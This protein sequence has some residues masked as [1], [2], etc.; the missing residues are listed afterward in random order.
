MNSEP[1]VRLCVFLSS[2]SEDS[3]IVSQKRFACRAESLVRQ[4]ILTMSVSL[5]SVGGVSKKVKVERPRP[6]KIGGGTQPE[7]G[8]EDL[9]V[10]VDNV[11]KI[12]SVSGVP[13]NN[14]DLLH[15]LQILSANLK[16]SG[17]A[18]E[19]THKVRGKVLLSSFSIIDPQD[20]MDKLNHALMSACRLEQFSLVSRL[21]MLELLELR[22]M[23]WQPNENVVNYYKQKLAQI[24]SNTSS[25]QSQTAP[26]M[27]N[28]LDPA[29]KDFNPFR[30]S[31]QETQTISKQELQPV[32]HASSPPPE[33][34]D[35][36]KRTFSVNVKIR[37]EE[38]TV[39]GASIDLV[40]TA[41]IV[42]H[43]FFNI[44]PP[45]K[46]ETESEELEAPVVFV[47]PD[48]TYNKQELLAMSKSPLC[49]KTPVSWD[50]IVKE[51]PGVARRPERA[52]PTS[53]LIL[54]EMEGLR[55]QEEAKN[56]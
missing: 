16:I 25:G 43:E 30:A 21:H 3:N 56:V 23:N 29:A 42:L 15:K 1:G 45:S 14:L 26:P 7:L 35:Q 48:I 44:C 11:K 36:E 32:N 22:S 50:N 55:K 34:K 40:K 24:E 54:R 4:T 8:V 6:L 10:V 47:K 52:G 27:S 28:L 12:L 39:T 31:F 53:K 20:T 18:L 9:L 41:K 5:K 49:R 2:Q 46:A 37:N 33:L 13:E 17:S 51:L 38:L 19:R